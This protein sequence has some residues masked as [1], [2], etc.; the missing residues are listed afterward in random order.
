LAFSIEE[1]LI[2]TFFILKK[3]IKLPYRDFGVIK[4]VYSLEGL[5]SKKNKEELDTY[6]Q[7]SIPYCQV[8]PIKP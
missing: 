8:R 4:K 1:K 2:Q 5:Y 3:F 7:K 6:F